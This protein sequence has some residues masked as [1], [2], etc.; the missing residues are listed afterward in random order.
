MI[1]QDKTNIQITRLSYYFL[2]IISSIP[3]KKT[4]NKKNLLS[5]NDNDE[6]VL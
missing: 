6:T 3:I 4:E 5:N 1:L 2:E